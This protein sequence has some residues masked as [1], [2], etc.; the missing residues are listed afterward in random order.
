MRILVIGSINMDVVARVDHMPA[1]GEN[2]RGWDLATIPGGKGANQAVAA[3]RLGA[4]TRFLGRVGDDEFGARLRRELADAG[5]RVDALATVAGSA[6]G[7]ALIMVD[8]RGQNAIVVTAGA[9]GRL[10]PADVDAARDLVADAD[11]VILQFEVPPETVA[12][13]VRLAREVGTPSV[14]DAGPPRSPVDAAAFEAD[15]LTPNEAEAA[16]LLGI[17]PGSRPPEAMARDLLAR[18]PGAVVI[19]AGAA[20]A[21]VAQGDRVVTVPAFRIDPVDTTAAGD[22]FTAALA[23][24][25]VRGSDLAAAARVANAAGA[26]ACLRLGAQPSMPTAADLA[27]FLADPARGPKPCAT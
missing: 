10:T 17:A 14:V 27:A 13:G 25:V 4:E 3:A 19:K 5:P 18:G 12:R 11:A 2:V 6:S 9:N 15:V 21:V 24:E 1:P 16:S 22:A 23:I 20:G 8:A 7:V 26:L